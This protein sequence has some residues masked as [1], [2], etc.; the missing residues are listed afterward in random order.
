V[1]KQDSSCV[2]VRHGNKNTDWRDWATRITGA[3]IGWNGGVWCDGAQ[4]FVVL[5]VAERIFHGSANSARH[6]GCIDAHL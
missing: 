1:L 5:T 3:K 2:R 6:S 4:Q